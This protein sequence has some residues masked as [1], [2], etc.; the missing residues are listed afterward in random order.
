MDDPIKNQNFDAA[1]IKD[2]NYK[3]FLSYLPLPK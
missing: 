2:L 1:Y 3:N